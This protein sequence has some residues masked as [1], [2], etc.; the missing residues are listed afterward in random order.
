VAL[1]IGAAIGALMRGRSR[2]ALVAGLALAAVWFVPTL[3]RS[4]DL[5]RLHA[6]DSGHVGYM[7]PSA[8]DRIAAYLAPRTR[9]VRYEAVSATYPKAA[10][11]IVHDGR[12][13]LIAMGVSGRTLLSPQRLS[14]EVAAGRLRY[15]LFASGCGKAKPS[16]VR[17][18]PAPERWLRRHGT[19]VSRRAG[20]QVG[21]LFRLTGF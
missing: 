1:A 16:H 5:V 9:G 19:D 7:S 15:A 2:I 10:P 20:L 8:T 17:R 13:V 3:A 18:C 14:R 11:L 21:T 12:P 4:T 6:T